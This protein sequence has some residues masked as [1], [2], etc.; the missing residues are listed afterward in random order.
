MSDWR[1]KIENL[2]QPTEEDFARRK[3]EY[4]RLLAEFQQRFRCHVC[5]RPATRPVIQSQNQHS[6]LWNK[7]W[8]DY[9]DE[10]YQGHVPNFDRYYIYKLAEL[11]KFGNHRVD[12]S[13]PSDLKKCARCSQWTCKEH[14]HMGIC[15][16][17]A[18]KL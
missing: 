15:Q 17:C 18:E 13:R 14:I 9:I 6:Y 11:L 2:N 10:D 4:D 3:K 16:T 5:N 12:W 1:K 8:Y 7:G